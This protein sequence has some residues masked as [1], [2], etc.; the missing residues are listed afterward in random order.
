[1]ADPLR[2]SIRTLFDRLIRERLDALGLRE[3]WTALHDDGSYVKRDMSRAEAEAVIAKSIAN[4]KPRLARR[5]ISDW[6]TANEQETT[7]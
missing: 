4:P 7:Q 2:M 3:Q 1:M 6:Q 5:W